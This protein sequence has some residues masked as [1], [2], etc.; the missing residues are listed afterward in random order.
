LNPGRAAL[1]V[2]VVED[3]ALEG[4]LAEGILGPRPEMEV[5]HAASMAEARARLEEESFDFVI[6]DEGRLRNVLDAIFAFVGL[7][8]LD[9][10]VVD[11]NRVPL[12]ASGLSREQVVGRR[13]VDLSWFSHS[14]SER[15]RMAD[16]LARAARG[17]KPRLATIIRRTGGGLMHVDAAFSPL[18]DSA[19]TITHVVGTGVD[20]TARME[21]ERALAES[22]A[23][24][25]EAQR[26]AHVGSWQWEVG[27][28][29][30]SWSAE[31][32]RI[33]GVSPGQFDGS[34]R[35]FL[36]RVHPDDLEHTEMVVRQ[37]V[38]NV[39]PFIYDHRILRPDGSIR[40]LHTRG[41]VLADADGKPL[42]LV[43]S[44]W[45]VTERWEATERLERS[46]SLLQSTLE[47]T[48]DGILVVSLPGVVTALNRRLRALWRLPDEVSEGSRIADILTM[49][50]DQLADPEQFSCSVRELYGQPEL[51]RLDILRFADG[52]VFERYSRPQRDGG[53]IVGRVC[54]FRDVTQRERL[55]KS[56]EAARAAAESARQEMAH[57]L[58]RV[59]DGFTAL[60]RQWRYTYVNP[61]GGRMLGRDA[62]SLVGKHIWTE[63]PEGVGQK[64][65]L[66]YEQ[67]MA[68][69][70]P[71]QLREYYPPWKRWFENRVYP[72]PDGLSIFFTDV[73]EQQETQ[74]Q[75]R[76]STEQLRALAARLDAIREEERRM[77]AREIHDQ[78]GQA[79]TALKL[80]LA[81][82]RAGLPDG[83]SQ[84]RASEMDRLIDDTLDT[85]RRLSTELRPPILDDLGLAPAVEWQARDF[86]ARTGIRCITELGN[87]EPVVG[88]EALVLFRIV[89]EALTNV[90]R[91]A[92]ARTVR[93][94]L[95]V[96]RGAAVLSVWD[97]GR[98]ITAE[99]QAR[100]SAL[101]LAGMRERALVLGGEVQVLGSPSAGTTV[102]ARLPRVQSA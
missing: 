39:T 57:V 26:V 67:A 36:A 90:A 27:S 13:F 1:R 62:A 4:H 91:H 29:T 63:F 2:L 25:V 92:G 68:E 32:Y 101:G 14:A 40:M 12:V 17:E 23:R 93:I 54:S 15:Q 69:Q 88:P 34:Y 49:V 94:R 76:A 56:A 99:E 52:R 19:G 87:G 33:Y 30:V 44:C 98:G 42:R 60:D 31:L 100:P 9:G 65:Q 11:V 58:E 7:F 43:G 48:A 47:A 59:S 71:V 77:M 79:L 72:S 28:D 37:A 78:I 70:K 53:E 74:A 82:L 16:A 10:V 95:S 8:S 64:F 84:R 61:C 46:I 51:E 55:L 86:E 41:D 75:L 3:H 38:E 21:A 66:A 20:I 18:R 73:T 24:L 45:D 50:R 83:E 97:D 85:T 6:G 35:G 80:D 81:G 102:T 89:Q 96:D 5:V 22:E